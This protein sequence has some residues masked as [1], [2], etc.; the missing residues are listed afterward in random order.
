MYKLSQLKMYVNQKLCENFL[1]WRRAPGFVRRARED[2]RVF[3]LSRGL[4][5]SMPPMWWNFHLHNN[6]FK[7][8]HTYTSKRLIIAC[9]HYSMHS[10]QLSVANNPEL[11]FVTIFHLACNFPIS[12]YQNNLTYGSSIPAVQLVRRLSRHGVVVV[13]CFLQ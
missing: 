9:C 3:F 11:L 5:R 12:R 1:E 6:Y 10:L 4:L 2:T 7:L 8:A 13:H